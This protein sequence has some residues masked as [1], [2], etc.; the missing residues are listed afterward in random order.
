MRAA[1]SFEWASGA[2]VIDDAGVSRNVRRKPPAEALH[3]LWSPNVRRTCLIFTEWTDTMTTMRST[4]TRAAVCAAVLTSM[5]TAL[6][7]PAG[8]APARLVE[9]V[10]YVALGDSAAAA[11]WVPMQVASSPGC[12]RSTNNYPSVL[13]QTLSVA[14]TTDVTCSSAETADIV[15]RSQGTQTGPVPPQITAVTPDTD[16]VTITIGGN[17]VALVQVA[18]SC[19]SLIPP[20]DRAPSCA[21]RFVVDGVDTV[22]ASISARV[23]EWTAMVRAVKDAAPEARIVLVSYGT[24][25][26]PGGCFPTQPLQPADADY[27]QGKTDELNETQAH[28]A[29]VTGVEFFDTRPVTV[30]HDVC[31]EPSERYIEG[32]I[33]A[34]V[35]APLH[36][37]KAGSAAIGAALAEYVQ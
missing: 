36:P 24:Y 31:A 4:L 19:I 12:Q 25:I 32:L 8:A 16:L 3:G 1:S 26:R 35:A 30:G 29:E 9:P 22:S 17:D 13:A 2:R 6:A 28:I 27:L 14:S 5:G 11:P 34:S 37:N 23:P 18:L 15:S 7:A 10:D 20:S 21:D 33:P